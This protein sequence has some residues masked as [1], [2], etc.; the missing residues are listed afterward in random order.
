MRKI[1]I[2]LCLLIMLSGCAYGK[3]GA[4]NSFVQNGYPSSSETKIASDLVDNLMEFYPPG[5]TK[6]FLKTTGGVGDNF[7][8]AL[9]SALRTKG[10]T[11][12]PEAKGGAVTVAYVLDQI[13]EGSWYG[14]ISVSEG[15]SVAI[16]YRLV[17]DRLEILGVSRTGANYGQK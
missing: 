9:D 6:I 7:S 2:L 4:L 12:F 5:H 14:R 11:L 10:F 1:F 15:L 16:T 17:K 13:D 8:V 3:G